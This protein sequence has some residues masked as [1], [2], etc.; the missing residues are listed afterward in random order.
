MV[1]H[2]KSLTAQ[3]KSANEIDCENCS[4]YGEDVTSRPMVSH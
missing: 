1:E 4:V 2:N 3:I